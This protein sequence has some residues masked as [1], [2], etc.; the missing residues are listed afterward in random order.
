[1][2]EDSGPL[3]VREPVRG[4]YP[5]LDHPQLLGM[6][7]IDQMRWWVKQESPPLPPLFHLIGLKPV[8]AGIGSATY[9]M[10]ATAWYQSAAGVFPAGVVALAADGALGGAIYSALPP[11]RVL[12]TSEMSMN[13]LRPSS[14]GSENLIARGK[15]L[16][17]GR[18]L[19]LSEA[20]VEDSHGRVLAHTT[21]RCVLFDLPV[22]PGDGE[23]VL[24]PE[25]TFD[26]SD[27]YLRAAEGKL[28]PSE[29]L[30]RM[31]GLDMLKAWKAGEIPT[32]PIGELL[33]LE[34]LEI[35][36]NQVTI[37]MPSSE[38]WCT[39]FRRIYGGTTALF[40][41]MVIGSAISTTLPTKT[42]F[43]S[44]DMKVNF[45]RAPEP[46]GREL[47]G[48][49]TV[50]HRGR[51]L[52]IATCEVLDADMK[53]IAFATGT[54]AVL[55]GRVWRGDRAVSVIDEAPAETQ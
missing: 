21:C 7:G 22:P 11:G 40:A 30:E 50:V 34:P 29:E 37:S 45:I 51:T 31:S 19:A 13:Y 48:Y 27:P 10:P 42:S 52:A 4:T 16:Q 35:D 23:I 46:D 33:G 25:P 55:P 43:A 9:E 24:E 39:G 18:T 28:T 53:S 38:W 47:V 1:M 8:E 14:V 15:L 44:L 17:M 2:S 36:T 5:Y 41:D 26:T 6:S 54:A 49:G 32:S 3:I 12:A 20:T